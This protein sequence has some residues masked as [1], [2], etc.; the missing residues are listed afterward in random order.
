MRITEIIHRFEREVQLAS[1]LL[2]PNTV[3]IYDFGRTADGEP[4]YVMEFLDGV[5]L[6]G[7]AVVNN[8][9]NLNIASG[10]LVL[11]NG[12]VTINSAGGVAG[13]RAMRPIKPAPW[14]CKA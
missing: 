4:Y 3:E 2:H 12:K 1:Q 6:A 13:W 7:D 10:G 5:T 14:E 11:S 9:T 8:N